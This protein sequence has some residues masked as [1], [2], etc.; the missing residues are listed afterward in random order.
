MRNDPTTSCTISIADDGDVGFIV[1]DT[2]YLSACSCD[3]EIDGDTVTVFQD[4]GLHVRAEGVS[5]EFREAIA[6]APGLAVI[7]TLNAGRPDETMSV[8]RLVGLKRKD[9]AHA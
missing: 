7:N 1:S 2:R 4:G 6:E 3:V 8:T 5:D 9:D